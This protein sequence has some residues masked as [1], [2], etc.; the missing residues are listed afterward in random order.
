MLSNMRSPRCEEEEL[1]LVSCVR[2][3]AGICPKRGV[4]NAMTV[5]VE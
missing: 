4:E 1:S 3:V 5:I 2:G